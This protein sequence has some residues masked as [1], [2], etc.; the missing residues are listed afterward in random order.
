[1]GVALAVVAVMATVQ[2]VLF[3]SREKIG[4]TASEAASMRARIAD[5]EMSNRRLRE[6]LYYLNLPRPE[7]KIQN[8]AKQQNSAKVA[9]NPR[10]KDKLLRVA[11]VFYYFA[12]RVKS[13]EPFHEQL[14]AMTELAGEYPTILQTLEPLEAESREGIQAFAA[15]RLHS[16]RQK[17]FEPEQVNA[18]E[19]KE[20]RGG[21]NGRA[22]EPSTWRPIKDYLG[23]LVRGGNRRRPYK[24]ES[25]ASKIEERPPEEKEKAKDLEAHRQNSKII[26]TRLRAVERAIGEEIFAKAAAKP[27]S[28][29]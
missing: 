10:P 28:A 27:D 2:V 15:L 14:T 25:S 26:R 13:G 9:D 22:G 1:M 3:N 7:G 6:E 16:K 20:E 8:D 24:E 4:A 5:L 11:T 29:S 18:S 23:S 17:I 21:E 12:E 19:Q